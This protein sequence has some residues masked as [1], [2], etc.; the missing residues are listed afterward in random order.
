MK[1]ILLAVVLGA[2][3]LLMAGTPA[4]AGE[5]D[6][7]LNKLVEKG[8]LNAQEAQ[9]IRTETQEE[10]AKEKA[11]AP[12]PDISVPEWTRKIKMNGDVRFRTQTDWGKLLD[13]AHSEVRERIRARFGI[14][15]KV[16][17]EITAGGR[18]VTGSSSDARSTNITLGNGT[19]DFQ[20]TQVW[21]DKYY[22]E[23][24]PNYRYLKGS[25][26]WFGKFSN[27]FVNTPLLWD[28]DINPEGIAIQY[29]S[30]SF[31]VGGLP[32]TRLYGNGGMLWLQEIQKADTD[33]MMWGAQAGLISKIYPDWGTALNVGAAYYDITRMKN[34]N[35]GTGSAG[36]NSLQTAGDAGNNRAYI[37][38]LKYDYD[39]L[40]LIV[41]LDNKKLFGMDLPNHGFYGDFLYNGGASSG[42]T[43]YLLG[44]Y[45]GN[46]KIEKFGD[47][48]VWFE[49]RN[50]ERD[51]APDILPDSDFTG[52]SQSGVPAGGGT[53]GRG[54]KTGIQFG[55][56]KNTWLN[57]DYYWTEPITSTN[58]VAGTSSTSTP[59]Q[60]LQADINVKF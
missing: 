32:D 27:P 47:W 12:A 48:Y 1:R 50:L 60:L 52:F 38:T 9:A 45:L 3:F 41:R 33:P 58:S 22:I 26:F 42:N 2:L 23:Y 43:G 35:W 46:S 20:K 51:A 54:F 25:D 13:P 11:R 14:D 15:G 24:K 5:M 21:F 28:D 34:R 55:L 44:A 40:D 10:V 18:L 31:N 29:M 8:I 39:L 53:N 57:L 19:G 59:Y 6:V 49:W 36:T 16:N 30:P 56:L 17:D 7:L 37:G 4:Q